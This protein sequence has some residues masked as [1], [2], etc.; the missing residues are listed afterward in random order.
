MPKDKLTDYS[1]TN[2]SN[3]DVGGVNIDEGMLPSGVNNAIRELMTHQANAFGAGTPLY[4][5]ETNDRVGIGTTS[6]DGKFH[7]HTSSA[8]TVTAA[9]DANDLVLERTT[10][11]GMSMLTGNASVAR[12]KF[13]DP[14]ATNA[15]VIA[16]N[17]SNNTL[18]FNVNATEEL[19]IDS[20][21][22]KFN[23]DTA[24]ANALDDY[25]EGL[26][27]PTLTSVTG[28]FGSITYDAFTKGAYTKIGRV[29]YVT[30]TV[31]TDSITV[32]TAGTGV[33]ISGLPFA[34][35]A[36]DPTTSR[37]MLGAVSITDQ[38]SFAS[39]SP[40][41]GQFSNSE[42]ILQKQ[43][44]ITSNIALLTPSDLGTGANANRMSI[45]GFYFTD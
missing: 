40:N 33:K 29:V 13:A 17:H 4:V 38:T 21:G 35:A 37:N 2:A 26:F 44:A 19:R 11:V 20:D 32:G 27:D 42:I 16:Y 22:I 41:R 7:V 36:H 6:G 9:T 43:S 34:L 23:G 3:T 31:R 28:A 10:N 24:A 1:A 15:G 12:I 14:D 25:E 30:L 5:D 8:G 18:S 39:D 45:A